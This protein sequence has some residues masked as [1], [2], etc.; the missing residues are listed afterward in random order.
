MRTGL[1]PNTD[2]NMKS[3]KLIVLL[4]LSPL[5]FFAQQ[6]LNGLWMGTLTNDSST[7][8]KDQ[9]FEL[10]LAE[11]KGKVTGYSRS[12]FIVND[13]LYYIVKRVKGTIDGD[14]CE[15]KDDEIISYNFP[16]RLDKGVKVVSTFY[17]NKVDSIWYLAGDWKTNQ[18]K[19]YY[20]ISG[21][22]DLKEESDYTQSKLFP[23]LEEL[24]LNKNVPFYQDAKKD[25]PLPVLAKTTIRPREQKSIDNPDI[26][27]KP[28]ATVVKANTVAVG[29][30]ISIDSKTETSINPE[31][32][33]AISKQNTNSTA[34]S[35][36]AN[37]VPVGA[38]ISMDQK[39][40]TSINP[41]AQAAIN[42]QNTNSTA[43]SVKA[44]TVPVGAVISM[45]Q[46][47]ETSIGTEKQTGIN[48]P[49]PGSAQPNTSS[50][51]ITTVPITTMI[52]AP[53]RVIPET[54]KSMK[55]PSGA[56]SM[57]GERKT[58]AA[59]VVSY[60]SDSLVLALYDNG[61]ID[62]DTVSV[63]V[64]GQLF[65][66]K[67]GLKASAI[68]KTIY[69]K[70]GED[71]LTLILYAENLGKYPP[72]TGLLVVYDGEER[73]QIRFSADLN[74]NASVVFRRKK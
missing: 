9:A 56:A 16:R 69:I 13:T 31:A 10:I 66:A 2:I 52:V 44:N 55:D 17:R 62:G 37:T 60:V 42:K 57:V 43:S 36:K 5:T 39:T 26:D 22:I 4:V 1:L 29:S 51:R 30:V 21:K 48:K 14:V 8:R 35:V 23:H 6:Q 63:L 18:T 38:V 20:S 65:L 73:Y 46:K 64:N 7:V 32:Q 67:Q 47:T 19:K 3:L 45:D 28:N 27:L 34:S 74:K 40:E 54:P 72:N 12:S 71:D 50:I 11:Y 59:Q 24:G 58:D 15:I 68:K 61:E 53:D 49:D 41:E 25:P 70:P 33:A